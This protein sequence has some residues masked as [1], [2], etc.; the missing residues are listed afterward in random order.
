MSYIVQ[1][2]SNFYVVEYKGLDPITGSERRCW[3]H[4]G[5]LRSDA[6][7]LVRRLKQPSRSQRTH[8]GLTLSEF[9]VGPWLESKLS[10]THPTR[11]RY[12][13]MIEK[14]IGPRIGH[15]HLAA[16]RP[17]DLDAFYRD[18]LANG[19]RR[20]Q[21]LSEKT[22]LEIHRVVSNALDLAVDRHLIE[23]NPAARARPPRP[24]RRSTAA[25]VW[26]TE[27]LRQFL[28]AHDWVQAHACANGNRCRP[29]RGQNPTHDFNQERNHQ[30]LRARADSN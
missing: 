27:Q 20:R 3:H 19:G 21:G 4:C 11:S 14:N 13:W 18:V 5:T 30:Q 15:I 1:R 25:S 2:N 12:R 10:L 23:T 7:D 9:M 8:R 26:T 28:D 6:E 16:L 22:V 17:E 29:P 24:S